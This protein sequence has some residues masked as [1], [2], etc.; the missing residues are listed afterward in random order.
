MQK[1]GK[2][3]SLFSDFYHIGVVVRDAEEAARY[4]EALGIGP[5]WDS[6]VT[7]IDLEIYGKPDDD[8]K[9]EIK[10]TWMG[11]ARFELIQPL[12]GDSLQK[13]FLETHG[14]GGNHMSFFVSDINKAVAKM[15]GKGFD[16]IFNGR[17]AGGSGGFA[18]LG[19]DR[20]GGV[21]FEMVQ[22]PVTAIRA[23]AAEK[24]GIEGSLFTKPDHIGVVVRNTDKT[25][26]YYQSLGIET[27]GSE[28]PG[29]LLAEKPIQGLTAD[30]KNKVRVADV[31]PIRLELTQPAEGESIQKKFL[32]TRDE[33]IH[34]LCFMV[35]DIDTATSK[36]VEKG[37]K[38]IT[39][40]RYPK[41]GGLSYFDTDKVGGIIFG[42]LQR[43]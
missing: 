38:I 13:R 34:H 1:S 43:H 15:I 22:L 17:F 18:Y 4:Y 3:Q 41:G 39:Q 20:V 23:A 6:K 28:H 19:T 16:I 11:Q 37:F 9:I 29:Q 5:F 36:M 27:F 10:T 35:N 12:A 40:E 2:E 31:G 24:R 30:I 32:E 8:I 33:G 42:L 25:I 21:I 26:E 14:E 7:L